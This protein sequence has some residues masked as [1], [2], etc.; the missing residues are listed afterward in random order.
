[1]S[2]LLSSQS[3]DPSTLR[4][5]SQKKK[6][7]LMRNQILNKTLQTNKNN[8]T[9]KNLNRSK[10][11]ESVDIEIGSIIS[12]PKLYIDIRYFYET[13]PSMKNTPAK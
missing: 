4:S 10:N 11:A 12:N 6:K 8:V 5:K 3:K 7:K 9:F 13:R 1:M 2:N